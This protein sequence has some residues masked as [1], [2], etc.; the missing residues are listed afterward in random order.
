M[1]VGVHTQRQKSKCDIF[2]VDGELDVEAS[3][4]AAAHG[5]YEAK[6]STVNFKLFTFWRGRRFLEV[7]C[8]LGIG[9]VTHSRF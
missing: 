8:V 5:S 4:L 9:K 3:P 6:K 7:F 1:V 2:P